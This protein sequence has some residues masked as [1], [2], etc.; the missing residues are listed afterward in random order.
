MP[1]INQ[2]LSYIYLH[3]MNNQIEFIGRYASNYWQRQ[4]FENK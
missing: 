4:L 1:G 2:K 3:E